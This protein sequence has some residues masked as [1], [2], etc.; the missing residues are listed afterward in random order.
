LDRAASSRGWRGVVVWDLGA[1]TGVEM[2]DE[3]EVRRVRV[4][5]RA[6]SS[7]PRDFM[8]VTGLLFTCDMMAPRKLVSSAYSDDVLLMRVITILP[9]SFGAKWRPSTGSSI[10]RVCVTIVGVEGTPVVEVEFFAK[11]PSNGI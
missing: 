11:S 4:S 1:G 9:S 6:V 3:D 7:G 8:D 5:G 2:K 10:V